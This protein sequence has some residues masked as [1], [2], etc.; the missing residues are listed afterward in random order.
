LCALTC[1][2]RNTWRGRILASQ[3]FL[4]TGEIKKIRCAN[5][6]I[7]RKK[8]WNYTSRETRMNQALSCIDFHG[9]L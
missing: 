6:C 5:E 1:H 8:S 9:T 3:L 2:G 7:A 4:S